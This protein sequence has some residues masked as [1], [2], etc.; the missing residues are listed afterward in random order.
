M[1]KKYCSTTCTNKNLRFGRK[2]NAL[3]QNATY[4]CLAQC[5][6]GLGASMLFFLHMYTR[7]PKSKIYVVAN[8]NNT[9]TH[10]LDVSRVLYLNHVSICYQ[11]SIALLSARM[12]IH[13]LTK[14]YTYT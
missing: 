1:D 4:R 5:A 13:A 10:I 2:M 11:H 7:N 14:L 12:Y 6:L 8:I 3:Q 9:V